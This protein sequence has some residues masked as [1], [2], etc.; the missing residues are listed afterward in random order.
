M[1]FPFYPLQIC[2]KGHE[3][4]NKLR[5]SSQDPLWHIPCLKKPVLKLQSAILTAR[6]EGCP[7]PWVT[8]PLSLPLLCLATEQSGSPSPAGSFTART[9]QAFMAQ[10]LR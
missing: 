9:K 10:S 6:V 7:L 8:A 2:P 3:K 1:H 4:Q 5:C